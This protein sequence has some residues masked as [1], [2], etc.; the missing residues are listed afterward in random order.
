MKEK[1]QRADN[2]PIIIPNRHILSSIYN[3]SKKTTKMQ[4]AIQTPEERIIRISS[5][6]NF[7]SHRL[8]RI[9][10]FCFIVILEAN[11]LSIKV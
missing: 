8:F 3:R 1:I 4:P 5:K 7:T 9:N 10:K 6:L 11:N 2:L